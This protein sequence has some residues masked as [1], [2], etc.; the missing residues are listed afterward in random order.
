[1]SIWKIFKFVFWQKYDIQKD[2]NS[3][4]EHPV[5]FYM[6]KKVFCGNN[7]SFEIFTFFHRDLSDSCLDR[8]A[9]LDLTCDLSLKKVKH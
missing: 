1:M 3:T 2:E 8:Y 5:K 4:I 7:N 6:E 9:D